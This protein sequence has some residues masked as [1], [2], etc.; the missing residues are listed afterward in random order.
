MTGNDD[1]LETGDSDSDIEYIG[2]TRG[3]R[4]DHASSAIDGVDVVEVENSISRMTVSPPPNPAIEPVARTSM[5]S[6]GNT[7]RKLEPNT[8]RKKRIGRK[9]GK[10]RLLVR[11]LGDPYKVMKG[12]VVGRDWRREKVETALYASVQRGE[13]VIKV[14][15]G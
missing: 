14:S 9:V 13:H 11:L 7:K 10:G 4:Q 5:G 3:R 1:D 6:S 15:R 12:A 2:T 8:S